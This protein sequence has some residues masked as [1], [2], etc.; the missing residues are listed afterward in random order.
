MGDVLEVALLE[1]E[2]GAGLQVWVARG[3]DRA[4]HRVLFT[5]ATL[6]LAEGFVGKVEATIE[7]GTRP[8]AQEMVDLGNGLFRVLFR[9]DAL[10]M[11]HGLTPGQPATLAIVSSD[12][13]ILN[14]PWEYL[15]DP[16]HPL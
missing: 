1:D 3:A 11:Y 5:D 8:T 12:A 6:A 4:R 2:Q 9:G 14:L 16:A 15:C 7:G 13:R 10:R